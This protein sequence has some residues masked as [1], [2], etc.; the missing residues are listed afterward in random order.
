MKKII[1][2]LL[3]LTGCASHNPPPLPSYMH[4]NPPP[5]QVVLDARVQ[6][7]SRTE[8][9]VA[10]HDCEM[11]GLRAIPIISKRMVSGMMSDIIIDVQCLPKPKYPY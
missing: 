10:T 8:V 2:L 7:M 11:N 3:I 9:I 5:V 4:A 1:F 6:Q